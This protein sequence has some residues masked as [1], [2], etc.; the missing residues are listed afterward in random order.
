VKTKSK[1]FRRSIDDNSVI[2]GVCEGLAKHYGL[3]AGR[4]RW[5][6]LV[7]SLFFGFGILAYIALWIAI[8]RAEGAAEEEEGR[9]TGL[10]SWVARIGIS[11]IVPLIFFIVMRAGF[12]WLREGEAHQILI[13]VVAIVWGVGGTALLFVIS[14]AI[15]E[16]L[17]PKWRSALQPFVFVGPALVI[18]GWY[19]FMPVV[20]SLRASFFG[21]NGAEFVGLEN[22]VYVFTDR[23]M[24]QAFRNNL[25]WLI[26]GTGF[27]V[28]F[29]LLIAVL[30][31]RTHP[32]FEVIV[33]SIIFMPMAISFI[34]ASVIWRLVYAYKPAS[35]QQIGLL[36]AI[37]TAFG[38]EP[39]GWIAEE[40]INTLLFI[41]I[42]IWMQA[43]FA[44]VILSAALKGVPTELLEAGRIDGA[45]EVQ[46]FFNIMI[47]YI[48]GTII[49]VATSILLN[50]LKVFDIVWAM[51]GGQYGSHVIGTVFFRQMFT[52]G[53][54]GRASAIA[55]VLLILVIPM[56]WYNLKQFQE[57]EAF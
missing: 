13:A 20:R 1:T 36:N 35:Q 45:S 15:V 49:T 21:A 11:L 3:D 31:D 5:A 52:Y 17:N 50:T 42:L 12:I 38:G 9:P 22:Y 27:T 26:L 34:G 6:F 57:Q 44:M 8:P 19:L 24:L 14:N 47:P 37:I 30:A 2:G 16:Q 7:L 43:G 48:Q 33:K 29:G 46:I 41:V 55:I 51:T 54:D 18:L 56:M 39:V 53:H 10:V 4:I 23:V 40:P 28:I 32:A 25:L